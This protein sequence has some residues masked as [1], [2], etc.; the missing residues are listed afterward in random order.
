MSR[1]MQPLVPAAA[2]RSRLAVGA[3]LLAGLLWGLTWIPFKHFGALGLGG[4]T[5]AMMSYGLIGLVALPWLTWRRR[6]WLPQ[7]RPVA[8]IALTGGAANVCFVS[9]LVQGEVLRVMLLFY[10]TP[11]W[12]VLGGRIFFGEPLTALRIAGV[13]AAVAGAFL[14]LGGPAVL[15]APPG[16]VDGLALASGMLYASQNIATRAADRAPLDVK[17]LVVFVGCGGLSCALVLASGAPL[18]P[19]STMLVGQLAAFAGI[20]MMAAMVLTVYGVARLAAGRAAILLVFELLAAAISA[21]WI[22]GERLDGVEWIGAA[23]IVVAAL[24]EVRSDIKQEGKN[25]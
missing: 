25:A 5:L 16:I 23:L 13:G 15:A 17:T 11:V 22:A 20:W 4:L 7:L 6:T 9:A 12:G 10:L 3:L 1:V 21:M 2:D 18:P 24:L 14:L 8:L 19:L